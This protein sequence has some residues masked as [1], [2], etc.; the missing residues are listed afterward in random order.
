MHIYLSFL[1][2]ISLL[3][4]VNAQIDTGSTHALDINRVCIKTDEFNWSARRNIYDEELYT[5]M[6]RRSPCDIDSFPSVNFNKYL[7]LSV[8]YS[9][10]GC[11]INVE[12]KMIYSIDHENKK[13]VLLLFVAQ[14]GPCRP[15]YLRN[16]LFPIP[17]I[18]DSY[19][20][21]IYKPFTKV[22]EI[23]PGHY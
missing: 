3:I 11:E 20:I 8:S 9:Y 6:Q 21:E 18:P 15:N 14:K 4:Q 12:R 2:S 16:D 23:I 7:L 10:S 17:I 19:G 13:L 1:F 5:D 22:P